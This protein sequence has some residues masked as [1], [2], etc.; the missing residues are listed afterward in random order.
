MLRVEGEMGEL[1][2]QFTGE[3]AFDEGIVRVRIV[4]PGCFTTKVINEAGHADVRAAH[5]RPTQLHGTKFSVREVHLSVS[6]LS[7]NQPSLLIAV[8]I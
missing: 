1:R 2:C 4:K 5:H 6:M 7:M 8:M 3:N